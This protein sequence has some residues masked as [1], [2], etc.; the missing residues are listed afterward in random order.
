[1]RST[2]SRSRIDRT[3][4]LLGSS[5]LLVAMALSGTAQAQCVSS[6]TG[7]E[8]FAPFARGGSVNSLISVL[9][10]STSVFQAQTGSAFVSAPA[11]A[12]PGE[13]GGGVWGRVLGG[14]V[15][16]KNSNTAN[17]SATLVIPTVG[18]D[19]ANATVN[20]NTKT[21][22]DFVGYQVGRDIAKL[23]WNGWNV[24]MGAT[25]GYMTSQARDKT[26]DLL[27][28]ATF[29]SVTEVPFVGSY[30]AVTR[31]G[32][33]ADAQ[34]RWDFYNMSLNDNGNGLFNQNLN[35]RGWS[36]AG[37]LGY[38]FALPNNWFIEPSAGFTYSKVEVDPLNVTGTLLLGT[39]VSLPGTVQ[40]DDIKS[41]LGRLS[42][43]VGTSFST[44][45]AY[46][47]PFVTASV[48]HEFAGDVT[49]RIN[50]GIDFGGFSIVS[51]G[52]MTTNRVGTY[53]QIS[54][55]F[56][57]QVL[58]TG[59]L[60]Y[61]R[62]DYR[63]GENIEGWTLNTGLRYQFTPEPLQAALSGKGLVYKAPPAAVAAPVVWRGL[64]VGGHVG[65]IYGKSNEDYPGFASADIK[66]GGAL[67]GGQAGY[68]FQWGA[69][70]LGLEGDI[71]WSNA[72]GAIGNPLPGTLFGVP[73]SSFLTDETHLDWFATITGRLGYAWE[74]TLFYAKAG[75]AAADVTQQIRSNFD[76]TVLAA[77]S[78][79]AQGWTAGVGAEYALTSNWSAKAEWLYYDLGEDSYENVGVDA[80]LKGGLARVGVNYRFSPLPAPVVAKY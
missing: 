15:E 28:P 46:V 14:Q 27:T 4:T 12:A 53:G 11:N 44:P 45:Y 77:S 26:D 61:V 3:S 62:G 41:E 69:W 2:H 30:V 48:F 49:T 76:G 68:N 7:A 55:G 56:A 17:V 60:S 13:N 50:S 22:Q 8:Y 63:F 9:N 78:R 19:T 20:C 10:T 23:N 16:T 31:G 79:I 5:A 57:A 25:A 54:G 58:D 21:R 24:H 47:Q 70:V 18:T 71:A 72:K 42:V 66:Y 75:Y 33:F 65:T 43:R 1:M 67:V 6:G 36:V 39:G 64:Y 32:F 51:N 40:I 37:G 35:A 80:H 73:A 29:N 38:N 34:V 74:R 52:T 59:W